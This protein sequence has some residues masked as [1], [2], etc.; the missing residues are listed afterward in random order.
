MK[1]R[2]RKQE[3]M[4]AYVTMFVVAFVAFACIIATITALING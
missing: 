1:N 4:S 3:E 2:E